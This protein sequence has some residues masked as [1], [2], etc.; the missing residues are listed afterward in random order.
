MIEFM[1]R[2]PTQEEEEEVL[3]KIAEYIVKTE[4]VSPSIL[5]LH[6]L[7]PL[8]TLGG[9]FGQMLIVPFLPF[10]EEEISIII[11]TL[12]KTHNIEKLMDKIELLDSQ[13]R[14]ERK[15]NHKSEN[16]ITKFKKK[17]RSLVYKKKGE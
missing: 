15:I 17:I 8:G 4:M 2:E 10:N 13:K 5:M 9:E 7:R 3:N 1:Y 16:I 11:D 6:M 12:G 14:E